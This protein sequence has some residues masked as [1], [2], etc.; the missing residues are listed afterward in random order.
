VGSFTPNQFGLYDMHGNVW[1]WLEDCFHANYHGA[2]AD[3]SPWTAGADCQRVLR[4]GSW[5]NPPRSLRSALR[6]WDS[7]GDRT[8]SLSFRVGRALLSP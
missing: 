7:T 4:G 3:G 5:I 1:Q 6:Y 2:P 8:N